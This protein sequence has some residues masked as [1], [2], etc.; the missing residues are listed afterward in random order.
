V[1]FKF[2]NL[3]SGINSS[4][5]TITTASTKIS[6]HEFHTFN[7]GT[8]TEREGSVQLTFLF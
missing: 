2:L 1:L 6:A 7:K 8:L 4:T 5:K 3:G